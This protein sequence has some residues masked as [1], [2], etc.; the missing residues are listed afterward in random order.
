[1]RCLTSGKAPDWSGV[2]SPGSSLKTDTV[3]KKAVYADA[4]ISTYLIVFLN[5]GAGRGRE[6][7]G[8]LA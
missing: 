7:R 5:E 6:D 1:M 4:G 2:V 8:V 3:D